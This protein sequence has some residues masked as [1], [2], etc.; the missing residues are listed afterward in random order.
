ME[1]EEFKVLVK[2]M[3]AVY[4]QPTFIP[5]QDAFNVW[6]GL[7]QDLSYKQANLAIQ[8]YM[9]T[10]KFPPTIA[11]IRTR[12]IEVVE[13]PPDEMSE[14]EAWS[15]VRRAISNSNYHSVEEFNNL[16]E[17]CRIA[18]GSPA[19]LREWAMMESE[20]VETVEQSH[21]IRN[22][23]TAA[24]RI[25]EDRK[26]PEN[27]RN[28]IAEMRTEHQL[29][30]E[31]EKPTAKIEEKQEVQEE[32]V[33]GMSPETRKTFEYLMKKLEMEGSL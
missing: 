14:L 6:Y 31:K 21:F 32:T 1:R 23:R 3:K 8:K 13:K 11:D 29:L 7:L 10:E 20:Q 4:A 22:Y 12:A 27:I 25:T 33:R 19:N 15:L 24:K 28:M 30:E 17:V 2:G 5:D 26:I 9:L 16:P 18:V